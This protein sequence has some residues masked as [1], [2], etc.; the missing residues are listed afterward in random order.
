MASK[1]RSQKKKK[2]KKKKPQSPPPTS[3]PP[4][5]PPPTSPPPPPVCAAVQ[6]VCNNNCC[7]GMTCEFEPF[8]DAD[9]ICCKGAGASCSSTCDCCGT[10]TACVSGTCQPCTNGVACAGGCCGSGG[11]CA[12]PQGGGAHC[13]GSCPANNDFC[14]STT[15]YRC[16]EFCFCTTSVG[17]QPVCTDMSTDCSTDC[18]QDSD[19]GTE[20]VCIRANGS[21]C[22]CQGNFGFCV[23]D[24]CPAGAGMNAAE[25]GGVERVAYKGLKHLSLR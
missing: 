10:D 13:E 4:T 24:H 9:T 23:P 5:S 14:T 8:C 18:D 11:V 19:C 17:G 25:A 7:A 3:P 6:E 20:H 21:N 2:K 1:E 22:G 16:G 15:L 12:I